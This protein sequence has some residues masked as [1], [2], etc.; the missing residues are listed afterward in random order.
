VW[1]YNAEICTNKGLTFAATVN[2]FG[3]LIIGIITKPL[4]SDQGLGNYA[5]LLFGVFNVLASLFCF[6][7]MKETKGLTA[8]EVAGL[9]L[10]KE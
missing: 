3:T 2:W 8:K 6:F 1:L 10:K 9:Y 5:F 4:L 7:C